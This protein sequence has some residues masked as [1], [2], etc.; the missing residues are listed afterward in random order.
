MSTRGGSEIEHVKCCGQ[1]ST[2]LR[3]F[4][5]KDGDFFSDFDK[6]DESQ[7]QIRKQSLIPL[8]L[9]NRD[10][11]ANKCKIKDQLLLELKFGF[12]ETFLKI[13]KQLSLH[14]TFKTADLQDIN[15]KTVGDDFK[16]NFDNF[17]NVPIF[18]P[19]AQTQIMF[20]DSIKNSFILSF[21]SWNTD[22]KLLI[23]S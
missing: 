9:F 21:D 8:L 3:A 10:I 20:I 23:L 14:L 15:Y 22:K 11:A 4:T 7:A 17:F 13:T 18:F 12:Y 19:D 16:V 1:A 6:I 5:S 2:I